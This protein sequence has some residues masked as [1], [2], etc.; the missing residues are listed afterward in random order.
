MASGSGSNLFKPGQAVPKAGIY[1][2]LHRDHRASHEVSLNSNETF[3][4]CRQCGN[5]VRFKLI[6]AAEA[7]QEP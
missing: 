1:K 6:V 2:V 3:P 5:S 4:A 7:K